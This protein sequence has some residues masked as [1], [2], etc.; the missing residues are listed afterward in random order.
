MDWHL[1]SIVISRDL[2]VVYI[3]A[4]W[5]QLAFE[6]RDLPQVEQILL[7]LNVDRIHKMTTIFTQNEDFYHP[8]PF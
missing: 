1:P 5:L 7:L 2:Q 3:C 8:G 6:S 4:S